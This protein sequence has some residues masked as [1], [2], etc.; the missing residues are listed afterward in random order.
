MKN[1]KKREILTLTKKAR[2]ALKK[3]ESSL[4]MKSPS[5][6]GKEEAD[7][8][9]DFDRTEFYEKTSKHPK[10]GNVK[11]WL[12]AHQTYRF[13]V[14]ILSA[15]LLTKTRIRP[16]AI[17]LQKCPKWHFS[18]PTWKGICHPPA[19]PQKTLSFWRKQT[20]QIHPWS[21]LWPN[22]QRKLRKDP[23]TT[24]LN[25]PPQWQ[26]TQ[27]SPDFDRKKWDRRTISQ[28]SPANNW[29]PDF[30]RRHLCPYHAFR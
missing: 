7:S 12:K 9:I 30:G 1:T 26:N 4:I 19:T 28:L 2:K 24:P 25:R 17:I 8:N 13:E 14:S 27:N 22:L 5:M 15:F 3:K 10:F 29:T 20:V 16:G 11:Y 18:D 6:E 23:S 21:S